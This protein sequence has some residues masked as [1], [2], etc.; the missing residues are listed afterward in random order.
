MNTAPTAPLRIAVVDHDRDWFEYLGRYLHTHNV[1]LEKALGV[2]FEIEY[3]ANA[4]AFLKDHSSMTHH[5]FVMVGVSDTKVPPPGYQPL[6]QG[7]TD[8][9]REVDLSPERLLEHCLPDLHWKLVFLSELFSAR[10]T[11]LVSQTNFQ[12]ELK[13]PITD[14]GLKGMFARMATLALEN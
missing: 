1:H 6:L 5:N 10:F 4:E 14:D 13:K 2:T 9:V 11:H 7:E 3:F 12:P 8:V